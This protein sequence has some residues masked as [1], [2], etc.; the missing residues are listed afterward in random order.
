MMQG[1]IKLDTIKNTDCL[2][3]KKWNFC[4]YRNLLENPFPPPIFHLY[5]YNHGYQVISSTV[6]GSPISATKAVKNSFLSYN[7]YDF[8]VYSD[9]TIW[10][11]DLTWG[12]GRFYNDPNK[13]NRTNVYRINNETRNATTYTLVT[14]V[15]L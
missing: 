14:Y 1:K 4:H 3:E 10:S 15:R 7:F 2:S 11:A 13:L 9:S 6:I 5:V 12:K 8:K